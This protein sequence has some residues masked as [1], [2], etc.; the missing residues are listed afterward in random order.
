MGWKNLLVETPVWLLSRF[1]PARF[2]PRRG[3]PREILVLRPNDFGELLS[4]T[5]LFESL[6]KQFPATKLIAGIG[7]WGRPILE[8][9]PYIDEIVELDAPWNNK[10]IAD[11]S[12]K[13]VLRFLRASPQVAALRARGGFDVAIDVLGSYMGALLMMRLG[14]RYRVG[15]RGYRG[16]WSGCQAYIEY[17]RRQAGRA[18]LAQGELLG[19]TAL[20]EV[21]PQLFLTGDERARAAQ[22]WTVN[23]TPARPVVRIVAGVGAG[24]PTKA[25]P[26]REVGAAL[27][28]VAQS[29]EQQGRACEIVIVGS[30]ADRARAAEAIA[31]AGS[32]VPV[33]SLAGDIPMRVMFALVEQAD[34]VLTNSTMLMHVAAAFRRPTVAVLG[35]SISR[36]EVHDAIWGYP[37][38]YVSIAPAKSAD[39]Q[40]LTEWPDGARVVEAVLQSVAAVGEPDSR[41]GA[42][43]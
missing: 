31:A 20:P 27:A 32:S 23:A 41:L 35:G 13:N 4:T 9:N 42:A 3:A 37:A 25:W 6:R 11:R 26:A 36:P 43:A 34:T 12:Q 29:L 7:S 17:A 5:P 16:G 38:S 10:I 8:N 39:G 2:D 22:L 21:R 19:A 28:Q 18:A 33:R 14:A 15:V 40:R 1:H 30:D 24:V